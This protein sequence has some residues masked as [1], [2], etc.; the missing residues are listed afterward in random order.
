MKETSSTLTL[1]VQIGRLLKRK[2]ALSLPRT[3]S[4]GQFELM[5]LLE[6][7]GELS[8]RDVAA[9]FKIT[10]PSA[11]SLV[12]ELARMGFVARTGNAKDRRQVHISLTKKGTILVKK[13]ASRRAKA[14]GELFS[15]LSKADRSEL[16]R[17]LDTIIN[18]Q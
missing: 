3:A 13:I 4:Y 6:D 10:A 15:S 18:N 12:N 5:C 7:K 17:I 16:N 9:H 1:F 8:M 11:T 2:M 14:L